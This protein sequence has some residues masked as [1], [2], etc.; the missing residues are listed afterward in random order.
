M[1]N[2][3]LVKNIIPKDEYYKILEDL[4]T[5]TKVSSMKSHHQYNIL[6]KFEVLLC[7]DVEKLIK[8]P[9]VPGENWKFGKLKINAPNWYN[10]AL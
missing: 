2:I 6:K 9:G 10:T 1:K 5:A 4:K 3:P 7:G 8:R